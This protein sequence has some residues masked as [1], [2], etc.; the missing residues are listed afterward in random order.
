ATPNVERALRELADDP[1]TRPETKRRARRV[2]RR[3]KR[4]TAASAVDRAIEY[5]Y[6]RW[7]ADYTDRHEART[8]ESD[9]RTTGEEASG[10]RDATGLTRDE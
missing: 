5:V 1:A 6:V 9:T 4:Q 2:V 7:P 8:T 3:I 10:G